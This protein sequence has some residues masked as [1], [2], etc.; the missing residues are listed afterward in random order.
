MAINYSIYLLVL[1]LAF[2][3]LARSN[4]EDVLSAFGVEGD[5]NLVQL[6]PD[7]GIQ[8]AMTN[9]TKSSLTSK[10]SYLHGVFTAKLR[11]PQGFS[12]GIVSSF[13]MT[14]TFGVQTLNQSKHQDEADFEFLGNTES[15]GIVIATN[16]Y[17]D[18]V[19]TDTHEEGVSG[20]GWGD[21]GGNGMVVEVLDY[22]T[23]IHMYDIVSNLIPCCLHRL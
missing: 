22:D 6:L 7:G 16:Y 13:Y 8:I 23:F 19:G 20:S 4:G 14:S 21:G 15:K 9:T 11:L 10:S 12:A 1:L 3:G 18:G 17:A 5:M 2:G